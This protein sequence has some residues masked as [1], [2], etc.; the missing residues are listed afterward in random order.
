MLIQPLVHL[1]QHQQ[2]NRLNSIFSVV[3]HDGD[4]YNVRGYRDEIPST[5]SPSVIN[6]MQSFNL[7]S[8]ELSRHY[9][10]TIS[11]NIYGNKTF[12]YTP[13]YINSM[14]NNTTLSLK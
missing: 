3:S 13:I 8:K 12:D 9:I 10:K 14:F 11:Q 2:L 1:N 4:C 6:N 7:L 5:V